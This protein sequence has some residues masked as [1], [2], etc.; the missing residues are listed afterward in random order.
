MS[1]RVV[2]INIVTPGGVATTATSS[3]E[4]DPAYRVNVEYRPS[5]DKT[6]QQIGN[7]VE[8][9]MKRCEQIVAGTG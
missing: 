5:D 7:E 4:P 8:R 2:I 1:H 3:A 9:I 6:A